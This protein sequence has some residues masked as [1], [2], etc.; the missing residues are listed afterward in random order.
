ML[1]LISLGCWF[2]YC[3][4]AFAGQAGQPGTG[5]VKKYDSLCATIGLQLSRQSDRN[6]PRTNFPKG[7]SS[8]SNLMGHEF[9]G[10]LLAS[11]PKR[12]VTIQN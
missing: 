10:C 6:V 9:T 11:F 4:E 8:G 3:L 12:K 2:K 7:F 5:A 1:H